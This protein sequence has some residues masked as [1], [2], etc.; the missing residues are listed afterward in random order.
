MT[1]PGK[2]LIWFCVILTAVGISLWPRRE[3]PPAQARNAIAPN[4]LATAGPAAVPIRAD[5]TESEVGG[6]PRKFATMDVVERNA[7]VSELERLDYL[8]ILR[9]WLDAGRID[10]DLMKQ[11]A[12]SSKLASMMRA[13]TPPTEFFEKM[14]EIIA[15][16]QYSNLERGM[17]VGVLGAAQTRE[18]VE[19]LL[20]VASTLTDGEL[21]Q[22]A[23]LAVRRVGG[24]WGDGIF[25]EELSPLLERVWRES[26]DQELLV[27]VAVAMAEVGASSAVELLVNSV[28]NDAGRNNVR[29][30]AAS[31]ALGFAT[32]LNPQAVPPLAAVLTF[33]PPGS[34]ASKLASDTLAAMGIP[35]AGQALL[36]WLQHADESAAPLARRY[37]VGARTPAMIEI[38]EAS[39]SPNVAFRSEKIRE[40]VRQGLAEKRAGTRLEAVK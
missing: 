10:Q 32:I 19:V 29:A 30:R 2:H 37:V 18:S 34:D 26:R 13:R 12:M 16:N 7:L 20:E 31:G 36:A 35:A 3:S 23:I 11:G 25:H 15:S 17:L 22:S 1:K 28:L 27:S 39:L 33:Q 9:R 24:L 40:A 8:S 14:R 5:P 21:K 6:S 38:W 4:Q